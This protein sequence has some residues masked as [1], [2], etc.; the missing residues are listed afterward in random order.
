MKSSEQWVRDWFGIPTKGPVNIPIP[1]VEMLI[2]YTEAVRGE[3]DMLLS[4]IAA[5]MRDSDMEASCPKW[6]DMLTANA[7]ALKR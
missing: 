3:Y 6:D 5:K 7:E 1:S 4:E 2:N